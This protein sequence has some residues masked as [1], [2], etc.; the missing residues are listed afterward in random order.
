M[1]S[2]QLAKL[3]ESDQTEGA[4]EPRLES[5]RAA[6]RTVVRARP[7][8]TR[9]YRCHWDGEARVPYSSV[10]RSVVWDEGRRLL[11]SK[12]TEGKLMTIESRQ[13]ELRRPLMAVKP[14]TQEG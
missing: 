3:W 6:C 8:A 13:A 4:G 12:D 14:M 11:V 2:N 10:G 1:V 7:P 5:T 9:G